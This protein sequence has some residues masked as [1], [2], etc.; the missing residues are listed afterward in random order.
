MGSRQRTKDRIAEIARRNPSALPA[1]LTAGASEKAWYRA[2]WQT[3]A[4]VA[5]ADAIRPAVV[6]LT[7]LAKRGQL[8]SG[9]ADALR[10]TQAGDTNAANITPTMVTPKAAA[11][12]HANFEEWW[13]QFGINVAIDD[14]MT[15]LATSRLDELW[16][17][18]GRERGEA[19]M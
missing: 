9:G 15:P 13:L 17:A 1:W 16:A 4:G 5:T 8:T 2:S 3:V 11:F 6:I 18:F 12:L 10:A 7:W 14:V 19:G